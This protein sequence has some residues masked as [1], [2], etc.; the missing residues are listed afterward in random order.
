M[1]QVS[2]L[3]NNL[4]GGIPNIIIGIL[5]FILTLIVSSIARKIIVGI[6]KKVGVVSFLQ[7]KNIIKNEEQGFELLKVLGSLAYLIVFLIMIPS[8]LSYLGMRNIAD[9][10]TNM[11]YGILAILPSILGAGIVLFIGYLIAKI[12]KEVVS[13]LLKAVHLD[14]TV[15]RVAK[16]QEGKVVFSNLIGSI[17]FAVIFIPIVIMALDILRLD[18]VVQPAVNVMT[19]MF[20]F[21]PNIIVS[22][23]MIV[24]GVFLA[25][26]L[27][28]IISGLLITL[29][30]DKF[31]EEESCS[32]IFAKRKPST[33]IEILVKV[34]IIGVFTI[35]AINALKLRILS[36][37]SNTLLGY[38]PNIVAVLIVIIVAY[39]GIRCISKIVTSKA[40]LFV[41]KAIIYV[42]VGF[43]ILNQLRIAPAIVSMA[44]MFIMGAFSLAFVLAFGLGGKEFAKEQLDKINKKL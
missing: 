21:I 6:A 44:F 22:L 33:I 27:A 20:E 19:I 23:I 26:L 24:M 8:A 36:N 12:L 35:E 5:L 11:L 31:C 15:N 32:K 16:L 3:I 4:L 1:V 40:M 10:L 14:E 37:I 7:K 2:S 13:N 30:I 28:N 41:I 43:M 18:A 9:P 38:M 17:V 25:K 29:G 34:F 42:F 39:L